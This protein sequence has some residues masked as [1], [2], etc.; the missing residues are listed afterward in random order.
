[1]F[2]CFMVRSQNKAVHSYR[3]FK[4][5]KYA[6]AMGKGNASEY[7][8]FRGR[9]PNELLKKKLVIMYKLSVTEKEE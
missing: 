8:A 2:C 6:A 4:I 9:N 5:K 7:R 1:M 3:R